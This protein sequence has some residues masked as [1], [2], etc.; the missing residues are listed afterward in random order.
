[1]KNMQFLKLSLLSA[2]GAS[3]LFL[4]GCNKTDRAENNANTAMAKTDNAMDRTMDKTKDAYG[5]MKSGVANAWGDMRGY[6][7]DR[8]NDFSTSAKA[9][10]AKF[11]SEMS[12]MKSEY[13][14]AKASASRKAAMEELKN[15]RANFDQKMSALGNATSATWD[16]AKSDVIAAWDKVQAAYYKAKAN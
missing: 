8:K 2:V 6:S 4:V 9:M 12:V 13:S 5:D 1:M 15:S 3:S 11:D 14:E 7:F 10:T 16:S